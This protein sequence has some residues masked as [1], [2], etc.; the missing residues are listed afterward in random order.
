MRSYFWRNVRRGACFS[1]RELRRFPLPNFM[2]VAMGRSD[3][4]NLKPGIWFVIGSA[5]LPSEIIVMAIAE[6]PTF[7]S[8]NLDLND[9]Y[10]N[11]L[12]ICC[13]LCCNSICL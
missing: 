2:D 5:E 3:A 10:L 7:L 12:F 11:A 13:N 8:F 1:Q 4:D 6:A 9:Y